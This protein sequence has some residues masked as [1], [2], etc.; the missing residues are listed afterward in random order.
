MLTA[1]YSY[2]ITY[3]RRVD[4][5]KWIDVK[6]ID[7]RKKVT[8]FIHLQT[9][10]KQRVFNIELVIGLLSR[11]KEKSLSIYNAQGTERQRRTS[12]RL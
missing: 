11:S 6:I 10:K 12:F 3:E 2:E 8:N 7:D 1:E 5:K 4:R 9:R